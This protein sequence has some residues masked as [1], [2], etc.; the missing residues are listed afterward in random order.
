MPYMEAIEPGKEF[1]RKD[2]LTAVIIVYRRPIRWTD[3]VLRWVCGDFTHCEL[4][5][6]RLGGTF[7]TTV[8]CG[9]D[10]NTGLKNNYRDA[11][12]CKNY[13]WHLVTLTQLEYERLWVWNMTQVSSH[14]KYNYSDMFFQVTPYFKSYVHDLDN[15]HYDHPTRLFCSQ[16]IV[17]ALR[18]AFDGI[19]SDP[20]AKAFANSMNSRITTPGDVHD[21]LT[22]FTGVLANENPVPVSAMDVNM[23]TNGMIT[24][25]NEKVAL[26]GVC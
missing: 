2:K 21:S 12:Q 8:D 18:A 7:A 9:M 24:H 14:C 20:M 3:R 26:A 23:F 4:Y 15:D 25:R 1:A 19:D 6:P 13:A 10:F 11:K 22:K 5:I 17:L 16:S